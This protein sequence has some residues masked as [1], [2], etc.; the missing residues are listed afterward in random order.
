MAILHPS[1]PRPAL[2]PVANLADALIEGRRRAHALGMPVLVSRA[3]RIPAVDPLAVFAGAAGRG[4]RRVF[5]EHR[6]RET[7]RQ[8]VLAGI[9]GAATLASS[10]DSPFASA[11]AEWRSLL[12]AAL[13]DAPATVPGVGPLA[14]GGFRFDPRGSHTALWDGFPDCSLALPILTITAVEGQ[15]WLTTSLVVDSEADPALLMADARA[16]RD[17]VLQDAVRYIGEVYS[18][19]VQ[20]ATRVAPFL[21]ADHSRRSGSAE[22]DDVLS[23]PEWRRL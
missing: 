23:E 20:P 3:E 16:L 13:I 6:D 10:P 11:A 1:P 8:L 21:P 5:W 12:A 15:H 17:S 4:L 7:G 14:L 18:E 19:G 9:G 2:V 22:P